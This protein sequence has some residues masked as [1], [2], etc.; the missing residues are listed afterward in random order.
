[1]N[2][3]DRLQ[4]VCSTRGS[5]LCVGIDPDPLKFS[6][7]L[8]RDLLGVAQFCEDIVDSTAP[9]VAA[10]KPQIAYFS[11]I[12]AEEVLQHLIEYIHKNHAD[13]PVI[14]DAKR[15]DIG[16]TAQMYAREAFERYGADALTVNPFMGGDTL[17][18][19][20]EYE[21]RGVIVLCRTSN[22]GSGE[23]QSIPVN[24]HTLSIEV[25]RRAAEEW[26]ENNNVGLVTGATY[27]EE[28][29]AIRQKIG[30]M[31]LLVP[32][33]GA[34]GGDLAAVMD[35]GLDH[36]GGG[37]L[38]NASRSII[39]ASSDEDYAEQAAAAAK[40]LSEKIQSLR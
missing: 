37:L 28:L 21:N 2:F 26:N 9:Y 36:S 32:G 5:L 40:A 11:A 31:P 6:Q 39:H 18:P 30:L 7:A 22:P 17:R 25:A 3:N 23:F 35:A 8:A 13:I 1:M 34:Q 19:Y 10:Y 38:I 12:G 20:L 24:G 33:I 16:A 29:A 15:G 14:L 4:H 27:P